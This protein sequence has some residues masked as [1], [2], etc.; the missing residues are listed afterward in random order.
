MF[1]LSVG[2]FAAIATVM[3]LPVSRE[4]LNFGIPGGFMTL[5][6]IPF[7]II[8]CALLFITIRQKSSRFLILTGASATGIFISVVLHNAISGLLDTEEPVFFVIG[9]FLCPAAFIVGAIG[10]VVV[11]LKR[12][13]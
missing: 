13:A 6:G 12:T 11:A 8:G 5:L 7:A 9:I 10:S 2:L 4:F 3:A 1:W